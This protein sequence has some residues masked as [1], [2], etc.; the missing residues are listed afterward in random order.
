MV[1]DHLRLFVTVALNHSRYLLYQSSESHCRAKFPADALLSVLLYLVPELF[2]LGRTG[3][4][5]PVIVFDAPLS[6]LR[7]FNRIHTER[8]VPG[9]RN[10]LL[11]GFISYSE[12]RL[13][14]D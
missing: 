4:K 2:P 9:K 14:R 12:V 6:G 1:K 13:P 3:R 5:N 11:A 10:G 7:R 8:C